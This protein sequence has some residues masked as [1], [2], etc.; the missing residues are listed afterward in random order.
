[1]KFRAILTGKPR[2]RRCARIVN[3]QETPG[4]KEV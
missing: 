4:G 2:V 1:M 3:R